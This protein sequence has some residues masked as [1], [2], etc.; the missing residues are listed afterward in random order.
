MRVR[1]RSLLFGASMVATAGA[2]AGAIV[3]GGR[4]ALPQPVAV[5]LDSCGLLTSASP[6]AVRDQ[7]VATAVL[8]RRTGCSY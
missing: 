3:A 2:V 7:F 1:A 6:E 4:A 8:R 5:E